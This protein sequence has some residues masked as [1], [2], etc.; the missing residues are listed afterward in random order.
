MY[1]LVHETAVLTTDGIT[2]VEQWLVNEQHSPSTQSETD[3]WA[4][5]LSLLTTSLL[6]NFDHFEERTEFAVETV[7]TAG[8]SFFLPMSVLLTVISF[9]MPASNDTVVGVVACD[10]QSSD[11]RE[12]SFSCPLY[13][14]WR[15]QWTQKAQFNCCDIHYNNWPVRI[16]KYKTSHDWQYH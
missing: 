10:R 8:R 9:S 6:R 5:T 14:W 4:I 7:R 16:D 3:W 15:L 12:L 13:G 1:W 11:F 2:S